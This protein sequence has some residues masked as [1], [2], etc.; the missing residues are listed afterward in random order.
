M[1]RY[2]A[3]DKDLT[4]SDKDIHHIINVMRMKVNDQI[5]IVY[6]SDVFLCK[7]DN[8]SNKKV[9]YS[10]LEK[11]N[12][13]NELSTKV[14]IAL[15]LVT[16]K[17]IDYMLQKCTELGC[18]EFIIYESERS[19]VKVNNKIDNKI[20]RWNLIC[21][22]SAEQSFRNYSPKVVGIRNFDFLC[23]NTYNLKLVGST[24]KNK[25]TLKNVMQNST[26]CDNIII[27]IGPE[28]GLSEK[29]EKF[30]INNGY[31]GV[32]FG[33]TILRCETAPVF[34]MSAIKYEFGR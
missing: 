24:K 7:I 19:K 9:D 15:P 11:I 8:I 31:I 20:E 22:E 18:Y 30:L 25:K 12:I 3:K 5:Q 23:E 28:G 16:E 1:Q 32:T 21:K 33:N 2:F 34:V 26:N 13:N 6:D 17:K 4:L 27:V 14:T 29:E 10:V